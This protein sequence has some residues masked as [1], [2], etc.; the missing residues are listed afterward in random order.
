MNALFWF[1]HDLRLHDNAALLAVIAESQRLL[2]VY[3]VDSAWFHP[4]IYQ[5]QPLGAIRWQ[6]IR[7]SLHDLQ[8]QL[9]QLGQTL[10]IRVGQP[11]RLFLN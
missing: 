4:T 2:C 5:S 9:E 7:E 10:V 1:R 6:F 8:K 3:I 11:K